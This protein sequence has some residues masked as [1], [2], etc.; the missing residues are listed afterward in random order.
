MTGLNFLPI[1]TIIAFLLITNGAH[2]LRGDY[3][4]RYRGLYYKIYAAI[5]Y[6][7][8]WILMKIFY[9]IGS[10]WLIN[11][12]KYFR[13][14]I[15]GLISIFADGEVYT[16]NECMKIL[17]SIYEEYPHVYVGMRICACRQSKNYYSEEIS[18]VTDLM[19]IFSKVP[20][21]KLKKPMVYTKFITLDHAKKLLKKFEHEGFVHTMFGACARYLDGS[22][23][24]SIC[25]CRRD[26]CVPLS[27]KMDHNFFKYHK[28]HNLAI[29]NQ[30]KC[31]GVKECGKCI[32][33]CHFDARIKDPKNGKIK[34][35]N[36]KCYG[37][38][39]CVSHC[40]EGAN[41][42]K[43]LPHNKIYFYQNLFKEI[44]K[45]DKIKE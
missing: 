23:N 7:I 42:I 5:Y 31:K 25:N 35:L 37:C 10:G 3:K 21:E 13:T 9:K 34:I 4:W 44:K 32:E 8:E 15:S 45:K 26:T 39:L 28:P 43:F 6:R 18:N 12:S 14:V 41:I 29:I 36:N 38:G 17:D 24:L 2:L 22:A 30:K 33:Y 19:F 16:L 11:H 40:P 27:L 1:I 20:N